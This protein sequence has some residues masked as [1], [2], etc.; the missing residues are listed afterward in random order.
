MTQPSPPNSLAPEMT[1]DGT[2]THTCPPRQGFFLG[3]GAVTN[4]SSF[5]EP[6]GQ[7][8]ESTFFYGFTS[9]PLGQ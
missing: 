9:W 4:L 6:T 1:L 2:R 8:V 3:T 5:H 7:T